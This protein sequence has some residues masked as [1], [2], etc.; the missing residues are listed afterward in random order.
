MAV[1]LPVGTRKGLFLLSSDDRKSWK[2][3]GPLLEGWAVYHAIVDH[4][5]GTFHAAT[6]NPFYGATVHRSSD[7]WKLPPYTQLFVHAYSAP[8]SASR[9]AWYTDQPGRR[10]PS[11]SQLCKESPL[12]SRNRPLRVPTGKSVAMR[13]TR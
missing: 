2:V 11:T 9:T 12:R 4:R 8:A 5:N 7:R 3:E 6:N 13:G 10:G 1:L